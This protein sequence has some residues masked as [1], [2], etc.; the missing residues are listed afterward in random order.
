MDLGLAG[1]LYYVTGGS[2]GIGRA[3]VTLLLSEGARVAT[4]GRDRTALDELVAWVPAEH[5]AQLVVQCADVRDE[6]AIREA[7]HDA[8][9]GVGRLD[10]LVVNAGAGVSGAALRTPP[11]VWKD[12]FDIKVGAALTTINSALDVLRRSDAGRVVIVN[13]ITARSPDPTMAAVS[14]SRAALLNLMRSLAVELAP[15]RVLVNAVNVGAISTG[16]QRARHAT[17]SSVP[18]EE[19]SAREAA[20]RGILLSRFGRPEE[21]AP[22]VAL[23]LSPLS[24]YVT[25]TSIDVAGGS[26]G[27]L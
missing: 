2:R 14:A 16:R 8:A 24:S 5:R 18:Y 7:I 26:G 21:V 23:L 9:A 1:R 17:E 12:Q 13:G 27:Y 20:R 10:G 25:G 6:R 4:C 15:Q 22:M 11:A 19:W 3:V